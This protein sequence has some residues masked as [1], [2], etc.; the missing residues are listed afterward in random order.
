MKKRVK[1]HLGFSLVEMITAFAI[2]GVA[3]LGVGGFFVSSSRSYST[4]SSETGVQ[5]ETQMA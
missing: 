1:N 3:S 2:L 5:Y 4:S